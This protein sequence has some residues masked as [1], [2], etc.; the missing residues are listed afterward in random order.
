VEI[1]YGK[2]RDLKQ[3]A[4][5]L[6]ACWRWA[7]KDILDA[8]VLASLSDKG[9]YKRLLKGY[10]EGKRPLLLFGDDGALLGIC[11]FRKS[12][13]PGYPDDGEISAIYLRED[14]V[15]RGC[16]H[17]LFTRAEEEL[18]AQG[19]RNFVLDV[20]SQNARAIAFYRAHGYTTTGDRVFQRDG[21]EYPLDIMRKETT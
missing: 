5:L 12:R 9:R 14:A 4:A 10:R 1:R 13:T 15:G 6:N 3:A 11:R 8:E 21:K 7:Y 20:L 17:A 19:Y 16:G 18:R 2:R